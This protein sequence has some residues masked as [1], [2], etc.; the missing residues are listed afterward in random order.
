MLIAVLFFSA[1]PRGGSGSRYEARLMSAGLAQNGIRS[2]GQGPGSILY[3]PNASVAVLS[4]GDPY[5]GAG[6]GGGGGGTSPAGGRYSIAPQ[7]YKD[8]MAPPEWPPRGG[9]ASIPINI[10]TQGLPE[11]FQTMGI[12]TTGDG[13]VLPLYGR[14]TGSSNDRYNY[15]TR[16]DTFNP[17]PVPIRYQKRDCTDDVGC[18]ELYTNDEVFIDGLDKNAKVRIYRNDGPKYLP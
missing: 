1:A 4:N 18:N 16:S 15:Y 12:I 8:W 6:G 5:S 3:A 9:I 2:M 13:Q 7:P 11:S 10:P 14:R 17:M